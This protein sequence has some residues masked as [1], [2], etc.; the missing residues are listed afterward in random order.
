MVRNLVSKARVPVLPRMVI[1]FES[2]PAP[3]RQTNRQ[4]DGLTDGRTDRD[5]RTD[6]DRHTDRQ[7]D[8]Q[9]QTDRNAAYRQVALLLQRCCAQ[10]TLW[11]KKLDPF[12]FEHNFRKYCP[13]LIIVSLLQTE[14]ICPQTHKWIF[15]FIYSLLLHY[16]EQ[17][18]HFFTKTVE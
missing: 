1:S 3:G 9:K 8:R 17:C 13:I 6:R 14:I 11:V 12:S 2:I 16:L 10:Y 18:N 7:T 15:H 4:T 5:K